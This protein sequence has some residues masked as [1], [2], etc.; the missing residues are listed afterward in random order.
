[1][2]QTYVTQ[3]PDG[4]TVRWNPLTWADYN[5]LVRTYSGIAA[6]GAVDWLLLH[7]A[8]A[9]CF[10]AAYDPITDSEIEL[11]DLYAGAIAAVG[12]QILENTGF[13][14]D[15]NHIARQREMAYRRTC[16][17]WFDALKS[18]IMIYFHKTEDEINNY[19]LNQ[20]MD[21]VTRLEHVLGTKF[22]IG[23]E[24]EHDP[25]A[26]TQFQQLEDGTRIPVID[27][28]ALENR[29]PINVEK[30]IEKYQHFDRDGRPPMRPAGPKHPAR[31]AAER[32]EKVHPL[33]QEMIDK[34]LI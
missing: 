1:M 12:T 2:A 9:L 19:T 32:G 15:V 26:P 4:T 6:L 20:F 30:E 21:Y 29:N 14:E 18:Y 3:L 10:I 22:P 23:N 13:L 33:R 24:T 34:G 31:A 8:T 28:R 27:R 7:A 5:E 25:N 16:Y 11:D 17:S